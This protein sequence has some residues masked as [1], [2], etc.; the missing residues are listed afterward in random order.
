MITPGIHY[1]IPA[2]EYHADE[3]TPEVALTA[4]FAID[5]IRCGPARAWAK[6]YLPEDEE[7]DTDQMIFGRAAHYAVLEPKEFKKSVVILDYENWRKKAAKDERDEIRAAGK[8]ALLPKD[9]DILEGMAIAMRNGLEVPF[10]TAPDICRG[11]F[12]GGNAEVTIICAGEE[13]VLPCRKARADYI[14]QGEEYDFLLDYKTTKHIGRNIDRLASTDRW[15]MRAAF[16]LDAYRTATGRHAVYVY[17]VQETT[18]PFFVTSYIV[19][20]RQLLDGAAAVEEATKIFL[21]CRKTGIWESDVQDVKL[22][23]ILT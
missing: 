16:Y 15:D 17:L 23:N 4:G 10:K 8:I 7:E 22:L 12:E 3:C 18:K 6:K 2:K 20:E 11:I 5:L 19:P 9:L 14:K 1:G 21:R 13:G